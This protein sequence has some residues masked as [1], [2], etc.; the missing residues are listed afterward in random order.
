MDVEKYIDMVDKPW[1]RMFYRL[2]WAQLPQIEGDA[3]DFGSGLGLTA[4]HLAESMCVV[5]VEP[6]ERT[7]ARRA[8]EH[9][10]EQR[11][12]SLACLTGEDGRFDLIVCHNVLEYMERRAPTLER[13]AACL[14]PGG[15]LSIIKHCRNGL[16]MHAAAFGGNPAEALR[17]YGGGTMF[18]KTM[19]RE[20]S[21]YS[22]A[23]LLDEAAR[24][25][26]V[27]TDT[28]AIRS[29]YGLGDN[30]VKFTQ[31]WQRDMFALER[32][33][34][35]DPAFLNIAMYNHLLFVKR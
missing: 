17:L 9:A 13:L 19:A 32:A 28:M 20:A 12:G 22:N 6:D 1:G 24:L 26:L 31:E 11:V 8:R 27:H 10:Y 35:R 2:A 29:F 15:T 18:A 23:T 30:E 4:S 16:V 14:K 34:E 7:V 5:A 33:V 3:L 25:S 21:S